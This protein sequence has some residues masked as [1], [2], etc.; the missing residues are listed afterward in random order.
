MRPKS[1]LK[2]VA[3]KLALCIVCGYMCMQ[4]FC[5]SVHTINI[6]LLVFA[7]VIFDILLKAAAPG[8]LSED[9]GFHLK[10]KTKKAKYV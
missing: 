3:P 10:T 9:F 4:L 8:I 1:L 6:V 5:L 2:N 7:F